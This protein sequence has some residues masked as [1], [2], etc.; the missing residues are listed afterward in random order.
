MTHRSSTPPRVTRRAVLRGLGAATVTAGVTWATMSTGLADSSPTSKRPPKDLRLGGAFDRFVAELAAQDKF[1]GTVLLA[2]Q[3]RPILTRTYGMANQQQAVANRPDTIFNLASITKCFTGL[4]VAQLAA[5]GKVA[6]QEKLGTY[7]PGF[8]A[9]IANVTVHQL[10]THTS[11]VGRPAL[12]G[13]MLPT[14]NSVEETVEGTLGVIKSTPLQ[15]T[16]GARFAYSND[17]YWLLGAIVAQVAGQSFYDYV[18]QHIFAPAGMTRTDFF[19]KPHVLARTDIARPYWTQPG[20][21]RVDF[22]STPIFGFI[23][24]PDGGAYSTAMDLLRFAGALRAGTLLD[25]AYTDLIT[26]A[27]HPVPPRQGSPA[28]EREFADYGFHD[29]IVAG[30]RMYGHPGSGPGTATNLDIHAD[31]DRVAIVLGNYDTAV[32]D[33]VGR[34]RELSTRQA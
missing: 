3:G 15:F 22:T 7:V 20:G 26:T 2:H 23:G 4:A 34:E 6:F 21:A 24:G 32:K 31:A 16:P 13:G 1:S 8:P 29:F 30:Q 9:E 18:R 17:G 14:W 11:G 33:I 27:K 12:G 25:P 10:L 5:Q 28:G 19:T